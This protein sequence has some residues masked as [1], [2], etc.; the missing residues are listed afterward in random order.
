MYN[1]ITGEIS[2]KW[3]VRKLRL[4]I[5]HLRVEISLWGAKRAFDLRF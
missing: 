2:Y 4:K 5:A 3:K 1:K